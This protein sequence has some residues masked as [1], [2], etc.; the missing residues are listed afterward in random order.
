MNQIYFSADYHLAHANIMKYCFRKQFMNKHEIEVMENG[1]E[2]DIKKLKISKESLRKHDN[3]IIKN[4]NKRIKENDT[5][6]GAGD[7]CFRNSPGGKKG[8]GL[9]LKADYYL[10]KLNGHKIFVRGN[11]DNNNSLKTK[12]HR[13]ILNVA[14]IY[15]ELVHDPKDVIIEDYQYYYPLHLVG[16][17]HNLWHT[18]EVFSPDGTPALCINVGVDVNNFRP[19]SLDEVLAIYNRWLKSHRHKKN[20]LQWIKQ[21]K[22]RPIYIRPKETP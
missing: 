13:I 15:I 7:L 4:H 20:I 21:S 1:S 2:I 8:E 16:H 17:I 9:I 6:Y 12:N 5:F 14:G 3:G 11:H 10:N 18:K 22:E 19:I